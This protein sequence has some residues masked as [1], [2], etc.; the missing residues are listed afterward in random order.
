MERGFL[1]REESPPKSKVLPLRTAISDTSENNFGRKNILERL[2]ARK[3]LVSGTG[4]LLR[5]KI[6]KVR[7][8]LLD[9]L[10]SWEKRDQSLGWGS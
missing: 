1:L 3:G 6:E 9:L 4:F 7:S 10:F 5:E 8:F 2:G